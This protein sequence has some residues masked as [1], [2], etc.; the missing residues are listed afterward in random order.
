MLASGPGRHGKIG[1][2]ALQHEHLPD[3]GKPHPGGHQ[4]D[5]EAALPLAVC[6][7]VDRVV[8]LTAP[9]DELGDD[10]RVEHRPALTDAPDGVREPE[11]QSQQPTG[12]SDNVRVVHATCHQSEH[13][14]IG[15]AAPMRSGAERS[16]CPAT[17]PKSTGM[18]TWAA[19]RCALP[20]RRGPQDD[21]AAMPCDRG[22]VGSAWLT[23]RD[24]RR[25][26]FRDHGQLPLQPLGEPLDQPWAGHQAATGARDVQLGRQQHIQR[27]RATPGRAWRG[28]F[29][30]Q[31]PPHQETCTQAD[32]R[33]PPS[34][35]AERT[36]CCGAALPRHDEM[37]VIGRLQRH[38]GAARLVPAP[39]PPASCSGRP[40]DNRHPG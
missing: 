5:L 12:C 38:A 14:A 21:P 22:G 16:G 27:S 18:D 17:T 24:D 30:H 37:W 33:G 23:A 2:V 11:G 1:G 26:W 20:R 13:P 9:S 7:V 40:R 25:E 6:Q 29:T 39:V 15:N 19:A 3:K 34:G 31:H 4:P 8:S 32:C 36:F 35:R 10:R 28:R